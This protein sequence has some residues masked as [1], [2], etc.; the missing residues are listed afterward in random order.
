MMIDLAESLLRC[1]GIDGNDLAWTFCRNFNIRR[2][3]GPGTAAVLGL[4]S[5]GKPWEASGSWNGQHC[6]VSLQ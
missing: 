4:I 6:W 5:Q 1:H 2:G 3:Y